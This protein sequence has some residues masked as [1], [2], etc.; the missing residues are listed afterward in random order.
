[1][2]A[3]RPL[4]R[5]DTGV[6][7][8]R[9]RLA[10]R[11]RCVF[12]AERASSGPSTAASLLSASFA[13]AVSTRNAAPTGSLAGIADESASPAFTA[14]T[15]RSALSA[16]VGLVVFSALRMTC[17]HDSSPSVSAIAVLPAAVAHR[18]RICVHA[19]SRAAVANRTIRPTSGT[20]VDGPLPAD[21]GA[22]SSPG[23]FG[24]GHL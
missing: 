24:A 20:G 7:A 18:G 23:R 1:V 2:E 9:H 8:F 13:T 15:A 10:A 17:G 14:P 22:C 4:A 11:W 12:A 16:A 6:I 19:V 3:P 21:V 5:R